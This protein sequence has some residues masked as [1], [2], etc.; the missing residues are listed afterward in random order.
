[1]TIRQSYGFVCKN[2][3]QAYFVC[4]FISVLIVL[5][6]QKYFLDIYHIL[7]AFVSVGAMSEIVIA[8]ITFVSSG[9]GGNNKS[10]N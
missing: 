4:E 2:F 5:G 1:M 8:L 7:D 9:S 6:L 3:F 10:K